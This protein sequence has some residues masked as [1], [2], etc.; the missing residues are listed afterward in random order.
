MPQCKT[1]F[2]DETEGLCP[3]CGCCRFHHGEITE[4]GCRSIV[5]EEATN[6][7]SYEKEYM[8]EKIKTLVCKKCQGNRWIVGHAFCFTAIKC[9]T[10]GYEIV[11]HEG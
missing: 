8:G 7:F 1:E 4:T 9:P 2:C 3:F 5:S 10:C 11:V 6:D